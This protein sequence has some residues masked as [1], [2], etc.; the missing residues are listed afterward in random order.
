MGFVLTT[1]SS[2]FASQRSLR[3]YQ[4]RFLPFRQARVVTAN[5]NRWS[6]AALLQHARISSVF[7]G[8]RGTT[9][10]DF[11]ANH[12]A[13]ETP[14]ARPVRGSWPFT[15]RPPVRQPKAPAAPCSVPSRSLLPAP[16]AARR[17]T[18]SVGAIAAER[19]SSI[20][21]RAVKR[22]SDARSGRLVIAGRMADVCAELDRMVASEG[23]LASS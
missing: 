7:D 19:S 16:V 18:A 14:P 23:L 13:E 20:P 9:A 4:P 11:P 21:P 17:R 2:I 12:W 22:V 15:V 3:D 1:L 6:V 5:K 8:E 10:P